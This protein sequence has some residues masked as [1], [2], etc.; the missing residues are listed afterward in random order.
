M[1]VGWGFR[2]WR[3]N[4]SWLY[5]MWR[6][7]VV[8]WLKSL[9]PNGNL[10]CMPFIYLVIVIATSHQPPDSEVKKEVQTYCCTKVTLM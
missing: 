1:Y 6:R 9:F 5:E 3:A 8:G 4:A 7:V 10:H 2:L